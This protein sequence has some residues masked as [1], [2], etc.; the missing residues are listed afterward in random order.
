MTAVILCF[1]VTD[2]VGRFRRPTSINSHLYTSFI[3]P[4]GNA[5]FFLLR[6]RDGVEAAGT[7]GPMTA[8]AMQLNFERRTGAPIAIDSRHLE[9]DSGAAEASKLAIL[10]Q[11]RK[12]AITTVS[13]YGARYITKS[14]YA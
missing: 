9:I 11:N 5:S 1:S 7:V 4:V 13:L 14:Q 8:I 3:C 2:A 12:Y 6:K 10:L